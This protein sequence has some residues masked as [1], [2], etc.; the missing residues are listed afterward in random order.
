[1]AC[2]SAASS[3]LD[4]QSILL[5]FWRDRA[6]CPKELTDLLPI[7]VL[8]LSA[9]KQCTT[10]V[11]INSVSYSQRSL[12]LDIF[13]IAG[14]LDL[15]NKLTELFGNAVLVGSSVDKATGRVPIDSVS[16]SQRSRRLHGAGAP[17]LLQLPKEL[18]E[19]LVAPVLAR[20]HTDQLQLFVWALSVSP[21]ASCIRPW[22]SRASQRGLD[23][24][25]RSR[26][27]APNVCSRRSAP[28][29]APPAR[30]PCG[31]CRFA[32]RPPARKTPKSKLAV[33]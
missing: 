5:V 16:Y 15:A 1:M 23:S 10:K 4:S 29:A 12:R 18:T 8:A 13:P 22:P 21:L 31:L 28:P 6:S 30:R 32:P 11:P 24:P 25:P 19:T 17:R 27:T 2:P 20:P 14:A 3:P 9:P 26:P 33:N 7:K